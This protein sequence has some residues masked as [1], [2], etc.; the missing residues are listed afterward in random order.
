MKGPKPQSELTRFMAYVNKSTPDS[1]WEWT[2]R[3]HNGYGSFDRKCPD[4]K[5]RPERAMRTSYRLLVEPIPEGLG[6]LHTCDNPKCV[7][8]NHLFLGT[9]ADNCADKVSKNRQQKGEDQPLSKLTEAEVQEIR[10]LHHQG[11]TLKQLGEQFGV[12]KSTI[13]Y[14]TRRKTWKHI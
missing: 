5:W 12:D 6:V 4:G 3:L 11:H 8:P 7:N 9:N 2:G 14:I 10:N 1:C 13:G